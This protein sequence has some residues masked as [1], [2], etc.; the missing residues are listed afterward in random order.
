MNGRLCGLGGALAALLLT[1]AGSVAPAQSVDLSSVNEASDWA[2]GCGTDEFGVDFCAV[3]KS[4]GPQALGYVLQQRDDG[5][6]RQIRIAVNSTFIDAESPITIQV[7]ENDPLV[8]TVGYKIID[9]HV[10]SLNGQ[11]ID[12]LLSE[13][14]TGEAVTVTVFQKTGEPLSFELA[15]DGFNEAIHALEQTQGDAA[16]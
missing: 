6:A 1:V 4:N 2:A 10:I 5:L 11:T 14:E 12:S 16:E 3:Q 7:D 9:G 13:L 15:L 8:W